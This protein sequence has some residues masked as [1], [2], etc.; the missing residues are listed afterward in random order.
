MLARVILATV[1]SGPRNTLLARKAKRRG[2]AQKLREL[3]ALSHFLRREHLQRVLELGTETGATLWVWSTLAQAEALLIAVDLA[4]LPNP[5][6]VRA[7]QRVEFLQADSHSAETKERIERLLGAEALDLLFI[8]ADH[9][10]E[11]VKSDFAMYAPLV[12]PGG[13]VVLHDIIAP[14]KPELSDVHLFWAELKQEHE[15]FEFTDHRDQRWWGQW[16]GL[17]VVRI[18]S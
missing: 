12:R 7:N 11:G 3:A 14:G 2:A 16:G 8:D 15:V 6:A 5:L 13:L 4:R 1:E 9:T 17:G 10:Y 18:P